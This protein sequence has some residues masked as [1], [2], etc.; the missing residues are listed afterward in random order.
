MDRFYQVG[1]AS[2][3]EHDALIDRFMG[4]QVVGY[5]VPGFA[6]PE[7]ARKA[8]ECALDI[9][10]ATGHPSGAPWVPVGAGVHTGT[11]FVGAVGK[12]G[13]GDMVEFTAI[14]DSVNIAARLASVAQTGEVV[15]SEE[16]FS[17]A[18]ARTD[19]EQRELTLKGVSAP[20]K[21]RVLRVDPTP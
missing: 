8:V 4:D 12:A 19:A 9:V 3:I 6:G 17:A 20:V 15:I 7:H 1:T 2:L 5:F 10:G 16:A 14:G 18:G 21:V 11:A 13:D